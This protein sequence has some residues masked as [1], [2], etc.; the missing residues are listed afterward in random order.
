ML[1]TIESCT[2]K[3]SSLLSKKSVDKY[4]KRIQKAKKVFRKRQF[5]RKDYM[6]V[7]DTISAPTASNDLA[8]ATKEET[9]KKSGEKNKAKYKF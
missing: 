6:Q 1:Q 8:R 7:N 5:S 3:Y 4:E 2:D 9:L